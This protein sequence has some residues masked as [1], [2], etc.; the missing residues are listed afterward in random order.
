M[1]YKIEDNYSPVHEEQEYI[2]F[3]DFPEAASTYEYD[4]SQEETWF[5]SV[6]F[7]GYERFGLLGG[8]IRVSF[9]LDGV[10]D[11][12]GKKIKVPIMV[13]NKQV[14]FAEFVKKPVQYKTAH[15]DTTVIGGKFTTDKPCI[16]AYT[17]GYEADVDGACVEVVYTIPAAKNECPFFE[18]R[19]D[20]LV[21][22]HFFFDI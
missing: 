9:G 15:T 18:A 7:S 17:F 11:I 2:W 5:D 21:S 10:F 6:D 20:G 14:D 4:N 22:C 3:A 12:S 13:D 16:E 1:Q 19:I 8:G